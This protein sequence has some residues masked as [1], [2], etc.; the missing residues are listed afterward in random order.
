MPYY[1]LTNAGYTRYKIYVCILTTFMVGTNPTLLRVCSAK[2][3]IED[4][5]YAQVQ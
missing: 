2:S 5:N 3:F 4:S 1:T